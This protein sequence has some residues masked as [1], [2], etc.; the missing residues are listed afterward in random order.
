MTLGHKNYYV[1]ISIFQE[2]S[3]QRE[4]CTHTP[5]Q[6]KE[7]PLVGL[8]F[9]GGGGIQ[10]IICEIDAINSMW[11]FSCSHDALQYCSNMILKRILGGA[12]PPPRNFT[13]MGL[14]PKCWL[15]RPSLLKLLRHGK[16]VVGVG[17]VYAPNY[18]WG[19][20]GKNWG[21][22]PASFVAPRSSSDSLKN[23]V[24]FGLPHYIYRG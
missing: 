7:W 8:L 2:L 15:S 5:H 1:V 14:T 21:Y 22:G 11:T 16:S 9:F 24:F 18:I 20:V 6:R 10:A 12:D 13:T 4:N 19:R 3:S 17:R 23:N